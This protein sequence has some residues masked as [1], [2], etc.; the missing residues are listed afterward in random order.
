SGGNDCTV[1]VCDYLQAETTVLNGHT[2]WVAAIGFSRDDKYLVTG[3]YDHTI[4]IWLL[5]TSQ[6]LRVLDEHN[7]TVRGI[8]FSITG[9]TF[10]SVSFDMT[11]RI[12]EFSS[13]ICLKIMRHPYSLWSLAYYPNNHDYICTAGQDGVA[14]IWDI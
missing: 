8:Q 1:R 7:D 5:S 13:G 10:A 2:A 6:C 9:E 12:W 3:S 11:L 4:R 14:Y